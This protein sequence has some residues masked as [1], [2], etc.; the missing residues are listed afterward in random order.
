M[1]KSELV[2]LVSAVVEKVT[3]EKV[4]K[5]AGAEIVEEITTTIRDVLVN[6]GEVV[7]PHVG[8]LKVVATNERKGEITL[9]DGTKKSWTK[10]AGRKVKLVAGKELKESL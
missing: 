9:Q 3:G 2:E 4:T 10:P 1:N 7:I 5:K 8:K 6:N